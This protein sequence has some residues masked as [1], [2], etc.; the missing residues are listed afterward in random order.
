VLS[1]SKLRGMLLGTH[2]EITRINQGGVFVEPGHP[3]KSQFMYFLRGQNH[4]VTV[5]DA[6]QELIRRWIENDAA[7]GI[8]APPVRKLVAGGVN[9]ADTANIYCFVQ[10][11]NIFARVDVRD[12]STGQVY[13]TDWIQSPSGGWLHWS[14]TPSPNWPKTL[15]VELTIIAEGG[16]SNS[17]QQP[18]QNTSEVGRLSSIFITSAS[19]LSDAI[20]QEYAE[21][22]KFEKNPI[23]LGKDDFGVFRFKLNN[24]SN[25]QLKIFRSALG[26]SAIDEIDDH[27]LPIGEN[28][29]KWEL[30]GKVLERGDYSARFRFD[31]LKLNTFQPDYVLLIHVE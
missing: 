9:K 22:A 27:N 17:T 24:P 19:S 25:L 8:G 20:L 30:K 16:N 4:F 10:R 15:T 28:S 13:L 29:E 26:S 2:E 11:E 12:E 5:S 1:A 21:F 18:V 31:S 3:E 7:P 6:E 23:Q 14:L